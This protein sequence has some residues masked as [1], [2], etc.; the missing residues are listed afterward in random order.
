[1]YMCNMHTT[2]IPKAYPNI[3]Q[4]YIQTDPSYTKIRRNNQRRCR[5]PAVPGGASPLCRPIWFGITCATPACVR[6][7]PGRHRSKNINF[8]ELNILENLQTT[9]FSETQSNSITINQFELNL[10]KVN[11]IKS[12]INGMLTKSN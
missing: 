11:Y 9:R 3:Y 2:Y 6:V 4:T 8:T 7:G 5:Q 12:M 1:M 10:I